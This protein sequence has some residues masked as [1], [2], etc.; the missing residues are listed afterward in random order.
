M[1]LWGSLLLFATFS[2]LANTFYDL[3]VLAYKTGRLARRLQTIPLHSTENIDHPFVLYLRTF[4]S[5]PKAEQFHYGRRD[6]EFLQT[7]WTEE[8]TLCHL[9][10]RAVGE[11]IALGDPGEKFPIAG[12]RRYYASDKEWRNIVRRL[13]PL[14]SLLLIQLN[15]G[16]HTAEELEYA[17]KNVPIDRIVLLVPQRRISDEYLQRF[18]EYFAPFPTFETAY[19]AHIEALEQLPAGLRGNSINQS[20]YFSVICFDAEG[21]AHHRVSNYDSTHSAADND[22]PTQMGLAYL[23]E[24]LGVPTSGSRLAGLGCCTIPLETSHSGQVGC[25]RTEKGCLERR[26]RD[27]ANKLKF[28]EKFER[29]LVD[30]LERSQR[31]YSCCPQCRVERGRQTDPPSQT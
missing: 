16:K 15:E 10:G 21:T 2:A 26:A 29:P 19:Q 9:V 14:A 1:P 5:D 22:L 30:A 13:V 6:R 27:A 11:V 4:R 20:E 25:T 17:S 24:L 7:A 28:E 18:L 8:E 12:A 23:F 31:Q 3:E